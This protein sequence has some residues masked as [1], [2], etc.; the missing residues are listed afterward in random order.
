MWFSR[1]SSLK[2]VLSVIIKAFGINATGSVQVWYSADKDP[3]DWQQ[4]QLNVNANSTTL[5]ELLLPDG[6]AVVI[7]EHNSTAPLQPWPFQRRVRLA[8]GRQSW[9]DPATDVL[10]VGDKLDA[11][12]LGAPPLVLSQW[13]SATVKA[14]QGDQV[15]V[16]MQ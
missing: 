12:S 15:L 8:M 4:M 6:A 2:D 7:E 10:K 14:V 5:D 16:L 9:K 13:Y 11:H 1:S 3:A